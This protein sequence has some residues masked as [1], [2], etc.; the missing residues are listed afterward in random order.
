MGDLGIGYRK[1]KRKGKDKTKKL[2]RM[3]VID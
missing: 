2:V 1:R 3:D